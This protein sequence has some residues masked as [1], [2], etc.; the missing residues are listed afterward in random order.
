MVKSQVADFYDKRWKGKT[1]IERP[2][3]VHSR[4][5]EAERIGTILK[6]MGSNRGK[7]L[8]EVGCGVGGIVPRLN[9]AEN[10]LVGMDISSF[11]LN[12]ARKK[13]PQITFVHGNAEQL[14]FKKESFDIVLSPNVIEH[15]SLPQEALREIYRILE[16]DGILIISTPNR[17]QL[18]NRIRIMM[19]RQLTKRDEIEHIREFSLGELAVLLGKAGFDVKARKGISSPFP[20]IRNSKIL[21]KI[22]RKM[23]NIFP[24]LS[25]LLIVKAQKKDN[26]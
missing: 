14:P 6:L 26:K 18:G 21:C 19:R 3:D 5:F 25:E 22:F 23:G 9:P 7:K 20:F 13:Y 17:L 15:L 16:K 4:V 1:F 12:V 10:E 8:L 24:F 11:A 2:R